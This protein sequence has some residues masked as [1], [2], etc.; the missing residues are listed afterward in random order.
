MYPDDPGAGDGDPGVAAFPV[1]IGVAAATSRETV[2]RQ[3]AVL[4][5]RREAAR[6]ELVQRL[7]LIDSTTD[8][9]LVLVDRLAEL[10]PAP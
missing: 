10:Q 3:L 4:H 2:L 1:V 9:M 5:A 6:E 7:I 8:R